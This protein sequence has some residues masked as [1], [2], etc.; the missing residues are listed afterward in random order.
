MKFRVLDIETIP[1]ETV[2]TRGEPAYKLVPSWEFPFTKANVE[3]V[4]PFP[5]PQAHRVVALAYVDVELDVTESPRYKC[6]EVRTGCLWD[7]RKDPLREREYEERILREFSS[8]VD[9]LSS[10]GSGGVNFVTWNGRGFD[11]PVISM[12]SLKLGVPCKWYYADR[13]VRYRF[14]QEGHL[15]LM[16]F[17]SD[18][19]AARNSKLGDVARL[20]GLP[21]KTDMT[22]ASVHSVYL[23]TVARAS[24]QGFCD[25]KM[26]EVG[27]YCLQDAVQTALVFLRTRFHL[28][29]IDRDE[30]HACLET[31]RQSRDVR[32]A[33][34][35]DWDAV[36][37]FDWD[38]VRFS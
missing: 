28:G 11:L 16:D 22:G 36:R 3:L 7:P 27:R 29:K 23:E 20:V 15:D 14:S 13:D 30:Y 8:S 19:G 12:R 9:A 6:G 21:G 17:L 38:A 24:D 1:D 33:I 34:D 4:E 35:V 26:V 37:L 2:W 32:D 5:P 25:G 10:G 18:Y 31:F